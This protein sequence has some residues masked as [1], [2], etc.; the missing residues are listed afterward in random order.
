MGRL[1]GKVV[2]ITG[3]ARGQGEAEARLF[4]DEGATVWITDV[5]A[6]EGRKL[7]AD[8]GATFVEHDVT[9]AELHGPAP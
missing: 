8:I 9:D 6:D 4:T 3:G 1:D 2:L 5:L 7:A